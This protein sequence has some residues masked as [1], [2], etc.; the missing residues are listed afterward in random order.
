VE[1]EIRAFH[2]LGLLWSE[3]GY[4]DLWEKA[5]EHLNEV[6]DPD[7][8][9]GDEHVDYFDHSVDGMWPDRFEW[10]I[11]AATIKDAVTAFE[12]YLEKALDEILHRPRIQMVNSA[13]WLRLELRV[14]R[15]QDSPS[16]RALKGFHHLIGN[17]VD[18]ARVREIR[19]FRHFLTHQRGE[20]RSEASL[21]RFALDVS[22]VDPEEGEVELRG[23][24]HVGGDVPLTRE[25]VT[26][27]LDDLANVIR[28]ADRRVWA[29]SFGSESLSLADI[30]E[31]LHKNYVMP[32]S[33]QTSKGR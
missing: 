26:S 12:V 5:E 29:L 6:F 33:A 3:R 2:R 22:T 17:E 1:R 7:I 13:E 20:I 9:A 31:L 25:H 14:N 16:W 11:H 28:A 4:E 15:G 10:M 21:Q 23:R 24:P 8:H 18:T 27:I 32:S 30:R 19:E